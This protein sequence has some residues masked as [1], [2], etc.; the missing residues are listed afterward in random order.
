MENDNTSDIMAPSFEH[1]ILVRD[2]WMAVRRYYMGKEL[3]REISTE[4]LEN[5]F[6]RRLYK[7][8]GQ[9]EEMTLNDRLVRYYFKT[10][11]SEE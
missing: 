9:N 7:E 10:Y 8:F 4:E 6:Y 1:F 3:N 11:F 2:E 5:D